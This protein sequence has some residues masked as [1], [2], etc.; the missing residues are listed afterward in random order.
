MTNLFKQI[1]K[2]HIAGIIVL[3]ISFSIFYVVVVK[4]IRTFEDVLKHQ[5]KVEYIY[6]KKYNGCLTT[7]DYFTRI[8]GKN[9]SDNKLALLYL[10]ELTPDHKVKVQE[11]KDEI[12]LTASYMPFYFY[13]NK[14]DCEKQ[15]PRLEIE[16]KKTL[17]QRIRDDMGIK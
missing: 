10:K 7:K 16:F 8:G 12:I 15:I 2:T 6:T 5:D 1:T 4:P 14:S 17:L 11:T 9:I 13:E 3:A